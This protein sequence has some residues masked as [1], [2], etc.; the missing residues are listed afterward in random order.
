MT[1]TVPHHVFCLSPDT[2]SLLFRSYDDT[3]A[4]KVT[5]FAASQSHLPHRFRAVCHAAKNAA[6]QTD[7]DRVSLGDLTRQCVLHTLWSDFPPVKR[8]KT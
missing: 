7:L 2:T 4:M 6:K 1:E 8:R 5:M 3:V